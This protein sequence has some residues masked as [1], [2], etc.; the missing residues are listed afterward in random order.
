MHIAAKTI[1]SRT[2][3]RA[4]SQ[5]PLVTPAQNRGSSPKPAIRAATPLNSVFEWLLN[6]RSSGGGGGAGGGTATRYPRTRYSR[7][8]KNVKTAADARHG[9]VPSGEVRARAIGDGGAGLVAE[10]HAH[11][12]ARELMQLAV[13]IVSA[14]PR[15]P[16]KQVGP[17]LFEASAADGVHAAIEEWDVH[18]RPTGAS[19][20]PAGLL[21]AA[22]A[23]SPRGQERPAIAGAD[24][25]G[26]AVYTRP[27]NPANSFM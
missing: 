18:R 1:G 6:R 19:T 15:Q 21:L 22:S 4:T 7:R 3:T 2:A 10:L 5:L 26:I 13:A 24:C 23:P 14:R 12:S 16:P 8:R 27:M 9:R 25:R 11:H 20:R 17:R